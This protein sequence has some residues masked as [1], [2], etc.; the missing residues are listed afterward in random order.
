M[1]ELNPIPDV[2]QLLAEIRAVKEQIN[3]LASHLKAPT[4]PPIVFQIN[5]FRLKL[6]KSYSDRKIL[7]HF[8]HDAKNFTGILH[9]SF[10]GFYDGSM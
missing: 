3:E 9:I 8:F 1:S 10:E 2:S 4:D 7:T 6:V 5:N